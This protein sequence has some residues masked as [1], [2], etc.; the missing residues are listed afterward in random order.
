VD[1]SASQG[2]DIGF[3]SKESLDPDYAEAAF[4]LPIGG[5]KVVRSQYGYHVIKVIDKKREGVCLIGVCKIFILSLK[6]IVK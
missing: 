6:S 4:T 2:G 5:V 3:A 1:S